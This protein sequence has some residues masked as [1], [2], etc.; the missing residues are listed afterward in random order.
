MSFYTWL[1][2]KISNTI[3]LVA[4]TRALDYDK[5]QALR[6]SLARSYDAA[7]TTGPNQAWSPTNL[8][9]D[10]EIRGSGLKTRARARDLERNNPYVKGMVRRFIINTVGE[11]AY[12]RP[13]IK[14][15]GSDALDKELSNLVYLEHE[16]WAETASITGDSLYDVQKIVAWHTFVDGACFILK[17]VQKREFKLQVLEVDQLNTT[18]DGVLANG[19]RGVQGIELDRFGKPVAYHFYNS[20][21]GEVGMYDATTERVLADRVIHI[22][23]KD[24]AS[25][26]VGISHFA[27]VVM[28]LFDITEFKDAVM[29]VQRVA[30][31]YGVFIETP[32]PEDMV[33]NNQTT[34]NI[35]ASIGATRE[36]WI[37][38]TSIQYLRVGEKPHSLKPEQPTSVYKDFVRTHLRGAA[39]GVGDSY[40]EFSGDY[41]G[42]TYSSAR[43]A[44]VIAKAVTRFY[45]A[46][47][48]RKLNIP[49]YRAWMDFYVGAGVLQLSNYEADRRR[50]QMVRFTRP[51]QD[52]IDPLREAQAAELEIKL[53]INNRTTII[54]DRG[55]DRDEVFDVL[56]EENKL[57]IEKG[58]PTPFDYT[59]GGDGSAQNF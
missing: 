15:A 21:P 29:L 25:Q 39:V 19:N 43:Q 49:I 51:R 37:N 53:G 16:D 10:Q 31:S 41:E 26:N 47:F 23:D 17:V 34:E 6:E 12:P 44:K 33:Y 28:D 45:N 42:S 18:V 40:E 55:G 46:I 1:T 30:A 52:W 4:P 32:Y 22:F 35:N 14:P 59:N 48:N 20:H 56:E 9:A 57:L 7:K 3:A 58:I 13:L 54:E 5:A 50:F 24:R 8:S 2:K 36:E 11:G 27:S 38:P